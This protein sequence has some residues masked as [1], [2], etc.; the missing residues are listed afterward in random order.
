MQIRFV[1]ACVQW[2]LAGVA[3]AAEVPD[4][5]EPE[6]LTVETLGTPSPHW[7]YVLDA[8]FENG[9]DNRVY[10]YDGDDYRRLGQIDAGF[11][12]SVAISPDGRTT[13]VATT[14]FARG[15][16]GARTDVVELTDNRTLA[17]EREIILPPKR[18]QTLAM[19]FNLSF[20]QDGRLLYAA[21]V[22]PAASFGVIDT[23]SG[24]ILGEIDTAGCFLVIPSGS[25]V[26]SLCGNGRLLSIALDAQ[27]KEVDRVLSEPFFDADRDPVFSQAVPTADGV[28]FISFLG[29]VHE[30]DLSGRTPAFQPVWSLVRETERGKWR[31]GGQQIGA[32]HRTQNRLYVPM[33][34]G[35]E[36]THKA[37]GTE[38]WVFDTISHERVARWRLSRVGL[39][40]VIAVQVSQDSAPLLF[41]ATEDGEFA[42]L[43]AQTGRLKHVETEFGQTPWAILN[44]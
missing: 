21:Y 34:R 14:Y 42:V 11:V 19:L 3:F 9:T 12:P 36:G 18:A 28:A 6:V 17:I 10:L 1:C 24:E 41:A 44:P 29:D 22:T 31:P 40:P 35:G 8:V 5:L 32:Y 15:G 39:T 43:D 26:T 38:I 2:V 25:G 7:A 30:V 13:A 37:G 20:S 4:A 33:H 16:H 23:S 27:G